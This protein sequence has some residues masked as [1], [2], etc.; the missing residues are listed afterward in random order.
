MKTQWMGLM[1]DRMLQK[2]NSEL[3]DTPIETLP[4]ETQKRE[5]KK[6]HQ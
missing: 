4:Y 3:E 5:R 6:Q 2:K 1:T